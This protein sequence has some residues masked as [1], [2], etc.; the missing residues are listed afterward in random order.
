MTVLAGLC[1]YCASAELSPIGGVALFGGARV[2]GW[3]AYLVPLVALRLP[4]R[5][6]AGWKADTP[7]ILW[8]DHHLRVIMISVFLGRT[9]LRNT[10]NRYALGR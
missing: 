7:L 4:I 1:V 9:F 2:R 6:A 8:N 5:F 3:Q 10:N